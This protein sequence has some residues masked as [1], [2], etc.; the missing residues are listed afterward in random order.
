[1]KKYIV[2]LMGGQ[3]LY[4]TEKEFKNLEEKTGVVFVPSIGGLLNMNSIVYVLPMDSWILRMNQTAGRLKDGT[5]VTKQFGR[6]LDANN[7]NVVLDV[8][9]YPEIAKDDIMTEEEF[10]FEDEFKKLK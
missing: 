5:K 10:M 3:K 7:P 1:M 6:W 9:H 2:A 8:G 4:I